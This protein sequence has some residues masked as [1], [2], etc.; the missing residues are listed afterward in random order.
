M[1]E[2]SGN[3]LITAQTEAP[4]RATL[5]H[6]PSGAVLRTEAPKDN[7]GTGASFSPTDL[8]AA[9]LITCAMTT[10]D[11]YAKRN[12]ISFGPARGRVEKCMENNP[13]RIAHLIIDIHMPEALPAQKRTELEGVARNCPVARALAGSVEETFRFHYEG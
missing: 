2:A 7:G 10:M 8:V 11:L 4:F 5:T 3:V 9:A 1:A 13:R 12:G 6:G